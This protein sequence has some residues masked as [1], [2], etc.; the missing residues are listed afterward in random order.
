MQPATKKKLRNFT[1]GQ[2]KRL[3]IEIPKLKGSFTGTGDLF[4]AL[5]LAWMHRS[6]NDL[7]E[8]LEKTIASLQ[9]VLKR[10]LQYANGIL[11]IFCGAVCLIES[12]LAVG[13]SVKTL[14]LNLIQSKQ[15]IEEPEV[16]VFAQTL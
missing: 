9:A 11:F 12:V 3:K 8:A 13:V 5:F 4:A 16:T 15:D 1:G 2:T 6:N 14:E 7:K 10:T